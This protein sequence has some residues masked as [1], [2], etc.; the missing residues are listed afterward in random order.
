MIVSVK[1]L[2]LSFATGHCFRMDDLGGNKYKWLA[3][4]AVTTFSNGDQSLRKNLENE[5][6]YAGKRLKTN[7]HV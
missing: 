1:P 5:A 6:V 2:W 3:Q 7:N 4:S